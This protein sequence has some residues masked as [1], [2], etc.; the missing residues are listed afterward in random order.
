MGGALQLFNDNMDKA[1]Q[2][3]LPRFNTAV[4]FTTTSFTYHGHPDP[5]SCPE[6]RSRRSLAY[7]YFSTGRPDVEVSTE[8]HSTLFKERKYEKFGSNYTFK[9]FIRDITPPIMIKTTKRLLGK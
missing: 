3:V 7:Y 9:S 6:E 4:I 5:L 8:K 2:T 1:V